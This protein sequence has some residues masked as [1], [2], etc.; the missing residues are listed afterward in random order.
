MPSQNLASREKKSFGYKEQCPVK[1]ATY[2]TQLTL[3][4]ADG[5]LPV[6]LDES[7][8]TAETVRHHGY[9]PRGTPVSDLRSSQQYRSTSLIAARLNGD[10][11]TS[12][13]FTGS[14]NAERFN[15]WLQTTLCPH[16]NA[17]HLVIMDNARWHKTARTKELIASRG[18]RLLYL[19][20]YSPDLN[21]IEHDFANIKRRW[22]YKHQQ[23]LEDIINMYQ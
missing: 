1:R 23:S 7:G 3:A 13:L 10:F 17:K 4:T 22:Q 20:P 18:A 15:E 11:V 19:P 16:L 12:P 2:K 6:Y 14:C 8:F 21:P 9:A 5:F